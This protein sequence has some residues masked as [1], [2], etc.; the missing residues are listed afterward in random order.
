[1]EPPAI[2][3]PISPNHLLANQV[4]DRL[5]QAIIEGKLRPGEHLPEISLAQQLGVSRS[6]V[7]E[8]L[9][10][11]EREGLVVSVPN[12]GCFVR[13][14]SA[15]DIDEIFALRVAIESLAAEWAMDRLDEADL[16][17]MA[18]LLEAQREA[19]AQGDMERL[20]QVDISFHEYVCRRCGHSRL[21]PIWE[22]IRSQ[23]LML[24]HLRLRTYPD[25]VPR[26]VLSDHQ[27]F[28]EAFR[29]RDLARVLALH[30]QVNQ[31]VVREIKQVLTKLAA[32]EQPAPEH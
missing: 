4:T 23:C 18:N 20:N 13:E 24:F 30:R 2:L 12:R 1:M 17:E 5:R 14:F 6:P 7:R 10:L 29:E 28:L 3:T 16:E 27:S 15:Q 9:R 22:G 32:G 25:Y 26:T 19:A 8:A 11:L 31:R 21:V